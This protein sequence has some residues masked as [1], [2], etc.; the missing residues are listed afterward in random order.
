MKPVRINR[1]ML[2]FGKRGEK[3][4]TLGRGHGILSELSD[5]TAEESPGTE[6]EE[7]SA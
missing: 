2:D 7:K 3:G 6:K 1:G 5:R 4:L